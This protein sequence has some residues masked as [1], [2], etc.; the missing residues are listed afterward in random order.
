[1]ILPLQILG[2]T[3]PLLLPRLRL[4]SDLHL[5]RQKASTS[6]ESFDQHHPSVLW[7]HL[8]LLGELRHTTAG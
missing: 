1:M 5:H 8:R 6:R 3:H 4:R 2:H 7:R